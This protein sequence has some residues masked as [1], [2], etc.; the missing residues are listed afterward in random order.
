MG[1][2]IV[3]EAASKT[4]DVAGDGTTTATVLAQALVESGLRNI[5]A[6]ANPMILRGGLEKA[7]KA[8]IEEIGKLAKDISSKE[9]KAQI[10]RNSAQSKEIGNLIAETMEKVGDNGVIT[11]NE[12]KGFVIELEYKEGMQFDKGYASPYFVTNAEKMESEINDPYILVT[13]QKVANLQEMLPMLESFVKVSK[14]LVIIAEDVEG[15]ALGHSS[16]K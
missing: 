1:A 4:N 13:D 12:G 3:K 8:V 7:S 6:G 11:V 16:C 2:Q 10:A 9:E 5:S 15:E 14:N